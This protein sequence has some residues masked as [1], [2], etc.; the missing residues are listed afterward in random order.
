MVLI[1]QLMQDMHFF[2]SITSMKFMKKQRT[3]GTN[4]LTRI[5]ENILVQM[6]RSIKKSSIL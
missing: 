4:Y 6:Y 3:K 1:K 5:S 2:Q